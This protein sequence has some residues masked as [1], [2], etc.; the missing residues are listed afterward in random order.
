MRI[1]IG[2]K[3]IEIPWFSLVCY[4]D[5]MFINEKIF[6]FINDFVRSGLFSGVKKFIKVLPFSAIFTTLIGVPNL[7]QISTKL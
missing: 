5:Q 7:D 2:Q 3:P 4:G 1:L 6:I